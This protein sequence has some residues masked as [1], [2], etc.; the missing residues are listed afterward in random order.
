MSFMAANVRNNVDEFYKIIPNDELS[1]EDKTYFPYGKPY[2]P[3]FEK[4]K[5]KYIWVNDLISSLEKD[6]VLSRGKQLNELG[7][8]VSQF[9]TN[10]NQ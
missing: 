4:M 6:Y 8:I 5:Y 9:Y 2:F 1:G 10:F 7:N 3:L